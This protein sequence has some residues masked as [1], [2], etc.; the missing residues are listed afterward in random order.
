MLCYQCP[1]DVPLMNL[2]PCPLNEAMIRTKGLSLDHV[3]DPSW[4]ANHN[5]LP[6]LQFGH[7][8]PHA[9]TSDA[10]MTLC[11]KVVS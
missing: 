2:V 5:M 7:V 10:G 4:C 8:C 9:G 11:I 3:V 6:H 1:R